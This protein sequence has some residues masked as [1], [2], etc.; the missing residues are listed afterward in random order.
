MG[1]DGAVLLDDV[2]DSSPG[3]SESARATS[4]PRLADERQARPGLLT[5]DSKQQLGYRFR[6]KMQLYTIFQQSFF[7]CWLY[8]LLLHN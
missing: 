7:L 3:A 4:A 8:I 5:E 1:D 6:T 2:G